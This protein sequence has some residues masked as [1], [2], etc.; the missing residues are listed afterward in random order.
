MS[1]ANNLISHLIELRSRI[2][3]A[4][5]SVLI[6]FLCLAAFAQDLYQILAMP[7]LE[8]LPENSSMIATDVASPFFAPF[9]L[10][11]VLS[12]FIAIPYVLYQ[13][14]GFVAPG[15][16]RNEK[17]LVAPLLLSS[18]LLFYAGMAFAYFVVFPIA[19]AFFT[20]VAPEGVTVSTDISSYLNFVLKLFFAFGVSFEIPIAIILMC[21]TGVTDAKSLRAK[22]PYVV[23]GAFVVGMLLTPPDIISQTLLAIPMWLLFEVG[24]I[25]GGFYAGKKPS[26]ETPSETTD[27][28]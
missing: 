8:A 12:F 24:V 5:L 3:K 9:K 4:L 23:V 28:T 21:W 13:V 14:W 20:S 10:T 26:D 19:F 1:D 27:N 16:Y 18:T 22:R 15:L 25:V 17:R 11:L 6:V 2:L 7:L